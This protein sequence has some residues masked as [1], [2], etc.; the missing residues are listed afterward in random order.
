MFPSVKGP[1]RKLL[2][3]LAGI[4]P[5]VFLSAQPPA[6]NPYTRYYK[7]QENWTDQVR[8]NQVTDV[9]QVKGIVGERGVVDS[10]LLHQQ[11][12][13]MSANGG[14]LYFP[15][16]TYYFNFDVHLR[17]NV[18]IRGAE[19][20]AIAG[21][22]PNQAKLPTR[23]E[24]PKYEPSFSGMGTP[25]W[26]AFKRFTASSK[27]EKNFGLVNLDLN[28]ASIDLYSDWPASAHDNVILFGIRQNNAATPD[29]Q[30]PSKALRDEQHGWQRWPASFKE[31][32]VVCA[33]SRCV[34]AN[35]RLNDETTDNYGQPNYMTN[36][37]YLFRT[38]TIRFNYTYHPAVRLYVT[39][40]QNQTSIT[41]N[42]IRS[43]R[44]FP[45]LSVPDRTV[46]VE[47][48][49]L[50]DTPDEVEH[51]LI[52][53]GLNLAL[54][55]KS[56]ADTLFQ[57]LEF[58]TADKQTLYYRLLKPANYDPK[59]KYPLVVFFHGAGERGPKANHTS[60]FVQVF[61]QQE[62]LR[63]YPCFVIIPNL[64]EQR[65]WNSRRLSDPPTWPAAA[66]IHL[67]AQMEKDYN[68]D[69]KRIYVSGISAGG[70][71]TWEMVLRYPKR[72]AAAI[73]MAANWRVTDK[74]MR[75]LHNTSFF[76]SAGA[77][78]K[79]LPVEYVRAL[80]MQLNKAE[81]EVNYKE[82]ADMGH[83]SWVPLY[84]DKTFLPWLFS[85]HR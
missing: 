25:N 41:G 51:T 35:C 37:G 12:E 14:V 56:M 67:M 32:I 49:V 13:R 27:G 58:T 24:F 42:Y 73:P 5:S 78:D 55:L 60:H 77:L 6:T 72:F 47:N 1:F 40:E 74:Q 52:E 65:E 53:P 8:W 20:K 64:P 84:T 61:T 76:I 26:T 34:L 79:L 43:S 21:T 48:N 18:V 57:R 22:P 70:F 81:V 31:S 75:R 39:E 50:V 15:A 2:S 59:V 38:D 17:S 80:V 30:V 7:L 9:T 16:G 71:A 44:H 63:D 28:R 54:A 46:V 69:R 62:A 19:P 23:F 33:E 36:D 45:K 66:S 83:F 10:T 3:V 82:Y 29:P 11:L 4:L 85:K 68:I